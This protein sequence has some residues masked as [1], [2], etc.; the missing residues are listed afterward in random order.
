M[1]PETFQWSTKAVTGSVDPPS[2]HLLNAHS[3]THRLWEKC[4]VYRKIFR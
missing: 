4:T 1:D 2:E 3:K